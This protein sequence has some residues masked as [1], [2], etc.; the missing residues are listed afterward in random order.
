MGD[1]VI[2]RNMT[3]LP[4]PPERVIDALPPMERL[5]VVGQTKE[6]KFYFA[7]TEADGE[8]VCF[9]LERGRHRLMTMLD[10]DG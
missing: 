4:L 2:L 5:T 9:D 8:K 1:V 7:S 3:R 10:G 6:G